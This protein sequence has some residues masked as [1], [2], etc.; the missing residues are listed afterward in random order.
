MDPLLGTNIGPIRIVDHLGA[1]GMGEVYVG[2]DEKLERRVAVKAVHRDRRLMEHAQARLLHEAKILSKLEHPNICRLYDL[3]QQPEG[4][5]IV[6]ELLEGVNLREGM[7]RSHRFSEKLRMVLDICKALAAAHAGGVTHRDLKPENIM[8]TNDGTIKILDFGLASSKVDQH[9]PT[10][11][12]LPFGQ[13][14]LTESMSAVLK[15]KLG[16]I[17]GTIRYMSPE[18]A[19]GE[20]ASPASDMYSFGLLMQELFTNSNPYP[21]GLT[22]EALL[23]RAMNGE[24]VEIKGLDDDLTRLILRQKSESPAQRMTAQECATRLRWIIEKPKRHLRRWAMAAF[25]LVLVLGTVLSSIGFYRARQAVRASQEINR[26]LQDM[27]IEV[28]PRNAG[29]DL[30]VIDLLNDTAPDIDRDFEAYPDIRGDLHQSFG[31]VYHALGDY[32]RSQQHLNEALRIRND[33]LGPNHEQTLTTRSELFLVLLALGL[34]EESYQVATELQ[35]TSQRV[36]GADHLQT[37]IAANNVATATCFFGRFDEALVLQRDLLRRSTRILGA[38][39]IQTLDIQNNLAD[40]LYSMGRY[41]EAEQLQ[42]AIIEMDRLAARV[43][44]PDHLV[45]MMGYGHS[46]MALGRLDEAVSLYRDLIVTSRRVLGPDHS[47]TVAAVNSL[48]SSLTSL[49]QYAEAEETLREVLE[50]AQARY[51]KAHRETISLMN[52]L[53]VVLSQQQRF[54]EALPV[55][56]DVVALEQKILGEDH[57]DRLF[58]MFNLAYTLGKSGKTE[59]AKE[60]LTQLIDRCFKGLGSDHPFCLKTMW[61]LVK[62]LYDRGE[63]D[64]AAERG[65]ELVERSRQ[66]MGQAH[67]FTLSCMD[68]VVT[69]LRG[70]GRAHDAEILEAESRSLRSDLAAQPSP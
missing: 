61:A 46:L 48:A 57:P 65:S 13:E 4:D 15:T 17:K 67:P 56:R 31:S 64:Q 59:E 33:Q 69:V 1:G 42:S 70:A 18:Q 55:L 12:M 47:Q 62:I 63:F 5:F 49:G 16:T 23:W 28:D 68:L 45:A 52:S 37:L 32:K 25:V 22:E 40:T 30:K 11:E 43:E 2:Y 10:L 21:A 36:F 6:M 53:A 66:A 50:V 41:E 8:L 38:S 9:A 35:A 19:R 3:I 26:F 27:L 39:H 60:Q 7:K 34:Y 29:I 20:P 24:T 51:G 54:D 58:G 14:K 44:D